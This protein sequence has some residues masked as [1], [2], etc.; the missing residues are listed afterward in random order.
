MIKT[1]KQQILAILTTLLFS[2]PTKQFLF[3]LEAKEKLC[4]TNLEVDHKSGEFKMEIEFSC[5]D[6]ESGVNIF[7]GTH[8]NS[9]NFT[10]ITLNQT[11]FPHN[12]STTLTQKFNAGDRYMVCFTGIGPDTKYVFVKYPLETSEN[13]VSKREM[14]DSLK[15]LYAFVNKIKKAKKKFLEVLSIEKLEKDVNEEIEEKV[16]ACFIVKLFVIVFF[17][18]FQASVFLKMIGNKLKQYQMIQLPI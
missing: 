5:R 18:W 14:D 6:R 17:C 10:K 12:D 2:S 8:E 16:F 4:L 13:L 1:L 15:V 11:R 3:N 7:I 9:K